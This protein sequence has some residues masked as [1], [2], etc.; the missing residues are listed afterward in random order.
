MIRGRKPPFDPNEVAQEYAALAKEYRV[1]QITGDNYAGE[2][3]AG[4]F[5]T[6]G[7]RYE[8]SPLPKSALYLEGL[9]FFN[10]GAVAIPDV[11]ILSRELRLLE[12]RVHRSGR[13]SVDHGQGGSDDYANVVFGCLHGALSRSPGDRYTYGI[14]HGVRR[15]TDRPDKF[16]IG[17]RLAGIVPT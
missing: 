10:R 13:D 14:M 8:R 1:R 5:E 2:W 4:A 16:T 6:A 9:P 3:V 17:Q 15:A 12:R 7:L 11:A